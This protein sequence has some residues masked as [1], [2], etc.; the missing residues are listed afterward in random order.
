MSGSTL[1]EV[2]GRDERVVEERS[3]TA[4]LAENAVLKDR[5]KVACEAFADTGADCGVPPEV[6]ADAAAHT[7]KMLD[8]GE[9]VE[10]IEDAL[11]RWSARIGTAQPESVIRKGD[12]RII[13]ANKRHQMRDDLIYRLMHE[14]FDLVYAYA[15]KLPETGEPNISEWIFVTA[16]GDE[17]SAP[18][19]RVTSLL[20]FFLVGLRKAKQHFEGLREA[21]LRA[22]PGGG[23]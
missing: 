12:T 11:A 19:A 16:R 6:V 13:I 8:V 10:L 17:E 15:L 2:F 9:Q 14:H 5:L 21:A 23:R 3:V 18:P 4:L 20:R 7:F 22:L 1:A